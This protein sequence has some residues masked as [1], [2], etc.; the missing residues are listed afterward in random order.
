MFKIIQKYGNS[1]RRTGESIRR[2]VKQG[3]GRKETVKKDPE[4]EK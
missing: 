3:G 4:R 1:R 2:M